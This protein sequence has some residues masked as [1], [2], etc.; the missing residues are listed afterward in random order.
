MH[1]QRCQARSEAHRRVQY[2]SGMP[3]LLRLPSH[4][5]RS[6]TATVYRVFTLCDNPIE[7][8]CS[9]SG[10]AYGADDRFEPNGLRPLSDSLTFTIGRVSAVEHMSLRYGL[11]HR[12][13]SKCAGYRKCTLR[14]TSVGPQP[15]YQIQPRAQ[16]LY[17]CYCNNGLTAIL[18]PPV[19]AEPLS[20]AG[21]RID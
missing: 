16:T 8:R 17:N 9:Q 13:Q 4:G 21:H 12:H 10:V 6:S 2:G 14:P 1:L 20:D 3:M 7:S 5:R 18:Y 11:L 19:P 15:L